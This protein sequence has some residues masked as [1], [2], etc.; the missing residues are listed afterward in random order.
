MWR[1]ITVGVASVAAAAAGA[2]YWLKGEDEKQ[3][4]GTSH[5]PGRD[6]A[7]HKQ[8]PAYRNLPTTGRSEV[9][10]PQKEQA[11]PS[12]KKAASGKPQRQPPT[13]TSHLWLLSIQLN[14]IVNITAVERGLEL[15]PSL[16]WPTNNSI[17]L[18][19]FIS[20]E[21]L[22][23]RKDGVRILIGP[24]EFDGPQLAA[25]TGQAVPIFTSANQA[26]Q[27]KGFFRFSRPAGQSVACS[28]LLEPPPELVQLTPA[29]VGPAG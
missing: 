13:T 23:F 7:D 1:W 11:E 8:E 2:F 25:I 29:P 16:G 27:F 15:N 28:Q 22:R 26:W 21:R 24:D 4:T 12:N 9:R 6:F 10:K 5:T 19:G 18:A 17:V 20:P 3:G 14:E